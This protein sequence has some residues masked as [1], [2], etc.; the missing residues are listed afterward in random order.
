MEDGTVQREARDRAL[1]AAVTASDE[2]KARACWRLAKHH[3]RMMK[4]GPSEG[5]EVDRR[6]QRHSRGEFGAFGEG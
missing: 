2:L 6:S 4:V 1:Q 3:N 5:L